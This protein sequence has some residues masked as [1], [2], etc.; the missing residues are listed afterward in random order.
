MDPLQWMGAVRLWVKTADK[1]IHN[2]P[3]DS[4]PSED[5]LCEVKSCMFVRNES[6]KMFLSSNSRFWSKYSRIISAVNL[7]WSHPK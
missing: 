6:I 7:D 3:H 5:V 1:D 4:N 2:N